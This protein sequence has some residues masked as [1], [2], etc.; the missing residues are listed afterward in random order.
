M[1]VVLVK[2]ISYSS[3]TLAHAQCGNKYEDIVKDCVA[4]YIWRKLLPSST[5]KQQQEMSIL[6]IAG[7]ACLLYNE[8]ILYCNTQT[9]LLKVRGSEPSAKEPCS[10]IWML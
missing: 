7:Y 10:G 9:E 1:K 3:S 5:T 4:L 6:D 8:P 2:G